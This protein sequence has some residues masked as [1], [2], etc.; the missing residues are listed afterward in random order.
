MSE[1]GAGD[2]IGVQLATHPYGDVDVTVTAGADCTVDGAPS[3]TFRIAAGNW[4]TPRAVTVAAVDDADIE[5]THDCQVRALAA[6]AD[7]RY[8]GLMAVTTVSVTDND[9]PEVRVSSGDG[10]QVFSP[11]GSLVARI[12]LPESAA[13]LAFGGPQ[14]EGIHQAG[15][16]VFTDKFLIILGLIPGLR[17]R[18]SR[19]RCRRRVH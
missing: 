16:L 19:F 3:V 9:R 2:T 6:S 4:S 1:G 18:R 17:V 7:A 15:A 12:L 14:V 13:N 11:A 10:V 5:G 8:E